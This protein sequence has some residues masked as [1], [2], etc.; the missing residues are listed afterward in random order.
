[1]KI[2]IYFL[3]FQKIEDI[4]IISS[5]IFGFIVMIHFED[6]IMEFTKLLRY[7]DFD[8]DIIRIHHQI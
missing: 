3:K 5:I 7:F 4:E 1:M 2:L 8:F 6:I